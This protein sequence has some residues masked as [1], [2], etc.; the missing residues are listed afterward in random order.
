ML[1]LR[2]MPTLLFKDVGLVKGVQFDSWRLIGSVMQAV[3]VY[4]LREVDELIFLDIS[5]TRQQRDPD[6][7]LIDEI[8]DEC[9]MPLT[10]GGGIRNTEQ[11]ERALRV[12]ADKVAVNTAAVQ[13]PSLIS[14]IAE[15]FGTQCAV[16][17]I[18]VKGGEVV[19]ESGTRLTGLDPVDHARHMEEMGAGEL[20]VTSVERDGTMTGYDLELLASIADAV[21]I[22]VI[23]S[24]G[25]GSY[26]DMASA[27]EA[28]ASAVAAASIFHF[29]QQTPLE[30]KRFLHEQGIPTR[31]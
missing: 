6:Y 2:V 1:K 24:G 14:R 28:G 17:S 3:K 11:V 21:T 26:E 23:A 4:N 30:A 9:F 5:A 12:G 15:M 13:D 18:D 25:A 10:V 29:T 31:L 27:V 22:P 8:A 20:L 19:V 16:V 7:E